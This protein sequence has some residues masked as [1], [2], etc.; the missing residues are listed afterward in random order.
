MTVIAG[1]SPAATDIE[2][3]IIVAAV[4]A[5]WPTPIVLIPGAKASEARSAW[6]FS[7]R[8]WSKPASHRR[9]RP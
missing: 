6:R 1:I 7:G 2:A 8:W 9:Q 5:L 3:A 4:D